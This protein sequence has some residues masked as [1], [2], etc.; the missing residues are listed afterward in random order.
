MNY[1]HSVRGTHAVSWRSLHHWHPFAAD[2]PTGALL[3]ALHGPCQT[4][5]QV[6]FGFPNL[7]PA[8]MGSVSVLLQP[9]VF[10][11][12][13]FEFCQEPLVHP[14]R[15]PT[16][17]AWLS[18]LQDGPFLSMEEVV[19]ENQPAADVH[20]LAPVQT[21]SFCSLRRWEAE[22]QLD[23]YSWLRCGFVKEGLLE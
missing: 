9:L 14:C 11:L 13:P 2:I 3:A 8:C 6:N 19:L 23:T 21:W 16:S 7:T 17:L 15:L 4:Q 1:P 22:K 20:L 5:L 18:A 10:F 12:F